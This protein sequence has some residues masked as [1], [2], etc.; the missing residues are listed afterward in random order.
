MPMATKLDR[1][2][3]FN[4]EL[5][6]IMSQGPFLNHVVLQGHLKNYISYLYYYHKAY[7]HQTWLGGDLPCEASL[8]KVMSCNPLNTVMRGQVI[9]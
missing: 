1:V 4:K 5:P 7:G 9:N 3:I 8:Y 2:G 6:S